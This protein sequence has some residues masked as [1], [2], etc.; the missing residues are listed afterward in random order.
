MMHDSLD[1]EFK[2]IINACLRSCNKHQH[3]STSTHYKQLKAISLNSKDNNANACR[4][5]TP[6]RDGKWVRRGRS[7][8]RNYYFQDP[9]RECSKRWE[10]SSRERSAFSLRTIKRRHLQRSRPREY[11]QPRRVEERL[12]MTAKSGGA[13]ARASSIDQRTIR[14]ELNS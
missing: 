8:V 9:P 12:V 14:A 4:E 11:A 10:A 1:K 2:L 7:H 13:L 3:S 5:T 6:R